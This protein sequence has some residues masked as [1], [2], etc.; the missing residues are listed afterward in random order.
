MAWNQIANCLSRS[1]WQ[2]RQKIFAWE[3]LTNLTIDA[4]ELFLV[5]F[6]THARAHTHARHTNTH[7][8]HE[9]QRTPTCDCQCPPSRDYRE[10]GPGTTIPKGGGVH[11]TPLLPRVGLRSDVSRLFDSAGGL[12]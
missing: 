3:M 12:S 7:E 8:C 9:C 4:V 5:A 6:P 10:G 2:L 11:R 1:I